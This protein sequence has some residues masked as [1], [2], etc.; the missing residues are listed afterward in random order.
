MDFIAKVICVQVEHY[1]I[2]SQYCTVI[3]Q[4]VLYVFPMYANKMETANHYYAYTCSSVLKSKIIVANKDNKTT[5]CLKQNQ[6]FY[7][8][9][10]KG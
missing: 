5:A 9:D 7:C 6:V 8:V 2:W 1:C 3:E 4:P 10:Y